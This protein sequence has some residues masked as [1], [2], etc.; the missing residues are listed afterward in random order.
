MRDDWK[1]QF[2]RVV[3]SQLVVAHLERTMRVK[4]MQPVYL[5]AY[6]FFWN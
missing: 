2:Q 6:K 5:G 4:H 3:G 1:M